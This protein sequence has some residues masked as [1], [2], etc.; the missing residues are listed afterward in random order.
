MPES[1]GR[2][3]GTGDAYAPI[4]PLSTLVLCSSVALA[5]G[6][7]MQL[8]RLQEPNS[9]SCASLHPLQA[10]ASPQTVGQTR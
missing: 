4:S 3:V 1:Q 6:I 7:A 9:Q 5:P 10:T 8:R 2:D